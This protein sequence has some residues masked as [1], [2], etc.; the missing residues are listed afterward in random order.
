VGSDTLFVQ[1]INEFGMPKWQD[2]QRVVAPN[3]E[4]ALRLLRERLA[5]VQQSGME[6]RM[7]LDHPNHARVEVNEATG[8]SFVWLYETGK[9]DSG[10][11]VALGTFKGEQFRLLMEL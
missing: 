3:A 10:Y 11:H 5:A 6:V 1:R 7:T 8:K 9:A 4:A 2:W